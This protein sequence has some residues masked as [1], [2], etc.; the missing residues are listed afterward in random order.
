MRG[1]ILE[2]LFMTV[3]A[4]TRNTFNLKL[5]RQM[6]DPTPVKKYMPVNI[7]TGILLI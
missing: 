1:F 4:V 2:K 7:V 3:N 5:L 6:K